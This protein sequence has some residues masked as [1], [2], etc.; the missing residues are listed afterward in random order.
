MTQPM[1]LGTIMS[2]SNQWIVDIKCPFHEQ[3]LQLFENE[4]WRGEDQSNVK[5]TFNGYQYDIT[6][7]NLPAWGGKVVRSDKM[8]PDTPEQQGF[9]SSKL[10]KETRF[11][12]TVQSNFPPIDK[13]KF[14]NID[15][16][17]LMEWVLKV[18][19]RNGIPVKTIKVSKT[20][21]VDYS[22]GGYQAIHNHGSACISMVMAM[23]ETPVN[24]GDRAT[25]SPDN[26]MLY[27]LMPEPDG[28]QAYNQF[29]PYPGR[30]VIMDGRVWHG[31]YPCKAPRRTWVVDFDFEYFAPDE[32]FD[33]NG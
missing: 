9:P 10:L 31:V 21:C 33:P 15:W 3:F 6:P 16:K 23:D 12:P 17:Q 18:V 2:A 5:T 7:P 11:E 8:N 14:D 28:T 30:T 29:A 25:M 19:R 32:E 26:G 1:D 24:D 4:K 13:E 22:D 27:T 20:W